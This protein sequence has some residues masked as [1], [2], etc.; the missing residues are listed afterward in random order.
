MHVKQNP[1]C[2][3]VSSRR[4][5]GILLSFVFGWKKLFFKKTFFFS[6]TLVYCATLSLRVISKINKKYFAH[7]HCNLLISL[8][9]FLKEKWSRLTV[10]QNYLTGTYTFLAFDLLIPTKRRSWLSTIALC[11]LSL[12]VL[13][14]LSYS[15][16]NV[17]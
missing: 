16:A 1:M 12:P 2:S 7:L 4:K 14:F 17:S 15:A 9:V 8:H 3:S 6:A 10:L 13:L 11:A 5:D